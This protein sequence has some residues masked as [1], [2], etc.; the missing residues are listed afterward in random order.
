MPDS[1]AD[2]IADH[3]RVIASLAEQVSLLERMAGVIVEAL[4]AGGTVYTLGN[5]GSAADAQHI[6]AELVGRFKRNRRALRAV[7]LTTDTS[8]LTAISNDY[9]YEF[10]F[11]RQV[12]ALVSK[13]D[14]VWAL[15]VSGRS[16]NVL[17]A[18]RTAR[19][20]GATC[21]GFT[22]TSGQ[23]LSDLC[24]HCLMVDHDQSDRVQEAHL[25]AY[26]L[27]CDGIERSFD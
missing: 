7:A 10:V 11:A 19:Q 9:G 14:V 25:L 4:R 5:G 22:G 27:I 15:S 1:L 18:L 6:A 8:A 13:G 20:R 3:Q 12:E 17:E 26:H 23:A 16:P 2:Q 21:I 24:D